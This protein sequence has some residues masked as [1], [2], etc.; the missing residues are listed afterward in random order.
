MIS[1]RGG[2]CWYGYRGGTFPQM[3]AG[4]A[5]QALRPQGL[6]QAVILSLPDT[7]SV[8]KPARKKRTLMEE[9]E[10]THGVGI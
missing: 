5:A 3:P 9:G 1:Q 10:E 6:K 2:A 7:Y 4:A 8:P